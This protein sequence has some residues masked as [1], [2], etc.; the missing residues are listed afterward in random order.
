MIDWIT[1][2]YHRAKGLIP[3]DVRHWVHNLV[4]GLAG[5]VNTVFGHVGSAWAYMW[6][7]A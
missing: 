2:L 5:I 7:M 4:A 6:R 3:D 1:G